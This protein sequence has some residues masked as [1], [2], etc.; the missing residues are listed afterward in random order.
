MPLN[1]GR[2][3]DEIFL[4]K[5]TID[6]MFKNKID[7]IKM[8]VLQTTN[9]SI[10]K[11]LDLYPEV[12]KSWSYGL[13]INDEEKNSGRPKGSVGWAGLFNT[14][15][16]IDKANDLAGLIFMQFLRFT[17]KKAVQVLYDIESVIYL[18]NTKG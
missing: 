15:F 1:E 8:R 5:S 9:D 7:N 18:N 12:L 13:M 2:V 3:G 10:S 4:N 14:Y 16:W 11:N 17:D 6:E